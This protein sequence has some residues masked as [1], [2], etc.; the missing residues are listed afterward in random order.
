MDSVTVGGTA[1]TYPNWSLDGGSW[2][3][4][5]SAG[6]KGYPA[7]CLDILSNSGTYYVE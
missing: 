4:Y 1:I 6:E 3:Y 5:V 7:S 2:A